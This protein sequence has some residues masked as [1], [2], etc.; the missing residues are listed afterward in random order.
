MTVQSPFG[1]T[2]QLVPPT[3]TPDAN[4]FD[5]EEYDLRRYRDPPLTATTVVLREKRSFIHRLSHNLTITRFLNGTLG[6]RNSRGRQG[7]EMKTKQRWILFT[8]IIFSI[9]LIFLLSSVKFR[10]L[11]KLAS[12]QLGITLDLEELTDRNK[13]PACFGVNLCPA[14]F[15]EQIELNDWNKFSMSRLV[16]VKNIFYATW[17]TSDGIERQVRTVLNKFSLLSHSPKCFT[18]YIII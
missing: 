4:N 10:S 15:S 12:H 14:I 3:T 7:P 1:S 17:T 6:P 11:T 16:N 18:P 5:L 9:L 2:S 8:F 13:C